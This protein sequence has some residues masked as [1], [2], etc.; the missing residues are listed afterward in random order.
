MIRF[1]GSSRPSAAIVVAVVALAFAITGV[2]YAATKI[3]TKQ[4]ERGAVTTK[5][6]HKKA[7][8]DAKLASGAVKAGK[9]D[10]G[11]VKA[12][13]LDPSLPWHRGRRGVRLSATAR[14]S[15]RSTGS[16]APSRSVAHQERPGSYVLLV[17]GLTD[18]DASTSAR[19]PVLP[20][21]AWRTWRRRDRR[22]RPRPPADRS[23][24]SIR[25]TAAGTPA[26]RSFTWTIYASQRP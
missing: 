9:I 19:R 4:I 20:V 3:G 13:K 16:V 14:S 25:T 15:A 2:G 17:P 8:T 23:R 26:D 6:L 22:P 1:A 10:D 18:T 24:W 7:V 11:A 12:K 5:K 21:G